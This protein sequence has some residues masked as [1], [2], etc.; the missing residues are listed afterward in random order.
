MTKELT[1]TYLGLKLRNPL[2]VSSCPLT[3]ELDTLKHM[4]EL[5]AAAAVMPSL[6]E[7]QI[8]PAPPVVGRP[9]RLGPESFDEQGQFYHRLDDYNRGPNA[10][11][12]QIELA[13]KAVSIPII[14]SLNGTSDAGWLRYAKLIQDAGADALELNTYY[15]AAY[16]TTTGA[17]IEARYISLVE[18]I[19]SAVPFHWQSSLDRTSPRWPTWPSDW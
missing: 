11:L 19:R 10:Y 12:R 9:P 7:E 8:A 18:A 3:A 1:T 4:E 2:V 13:K 6:F 15:V 17:E 14:G 5:G 16:G